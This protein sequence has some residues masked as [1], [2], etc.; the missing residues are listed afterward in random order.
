[1]LL[2]KSIKYIGLGFFL[3][4]L[5]VSS[6]YIHAQSDAQR[7]VEYV[8]NEGHDSEELE[9]VIEDYRKKNS[10]VIDSLNE[11]NKDGGIS[12]AEQAKIMNMY[13][14]GKG[15]NKPDMAAML[16][17]MVPAIKVINQHFGSMSYEASR[18][19]IEKSISKTPA[20]VI[21][22]S[23]PK[24]IDFVTTLV[25]DNKALL[26]A[27]NMFKDK[28]KLF[29]F[30]IINV[31]LFILG[32]FILRK[33]KDASFSERISKWCIKKALLTSIRIG[34]LVYFFGDELGPTWNIFQGTFL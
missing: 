30:F 1:M 19:E 3:L 18:S 13:S 24:G 12:P 26:S 25:R 5:F 14:G 11:M 22:N 34:V 6:P 10:K 8:E 28:A 4:G 7:N 32:F 27:L 9:N 21:F 15:G 31:V 17:K 16:S 29:Q 33:S 20:K 2:S 23:M